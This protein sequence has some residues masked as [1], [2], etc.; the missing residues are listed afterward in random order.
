MSESHRQLVLAWASS[1]EASFGPIIHSPL[2][3]YKASRLFEGSILTI[4][5]A[6]VGCFFLAIRVWN[7]Q[8]IPPKVK[9]SWLYVAKLLAISLYVSLQLVL[10]T[11]MVINHA[12]NIVVTIP[13]TAVTALAFIFFLYASHLEHNRSLR[14]STILNLYLG[15]SLVV[16]I[17]RARTL[18]FSS[19]CSLI[20]A[21]FSAGVCAKAIILGLEATQKRSLLKRHYRDRAPE[22]YSGVYSRS[23]FLWVNPFLWKGFRKGLSVDTLNVL[24]DDLVLASDPNVLIERRNNNSK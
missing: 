24:D 9:R 10:L 4:V 16:D 12:S 6:L 21:L 15:F 5:P 20:V 18:W 22:A 19:A 1:D 8:R 2:A 13:A 17:A 7:L 3:G 14:P 23:L 11:V